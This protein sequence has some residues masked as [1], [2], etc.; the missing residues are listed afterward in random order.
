[1]N[2]KKELSIMP[3]KRQKAKEYNIF[4]TKMSCINLSYESCLPPLVL[5]ELTDS[6]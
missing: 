5:H 1:M 2:M 4:C 6:F 3:I